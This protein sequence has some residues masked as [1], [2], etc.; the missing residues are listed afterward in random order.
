MPVGAETFHEGLR[1]GA[2]VYQSL[3]KVLHDKGKATTV[4][5][6]GGFAPSDLKSNEQA[7]E[8]IL[9]AIEKAGYKAGEQVMVALDP[10]SS[11]FY[12]DGKY[13]LARENRSLSPEEMIDFYA[14]WMD[15]Y[16]IISLEDGLAEDDWEHWTMLTERIGKKVQLVGDDLL[17]TN[18]EY[19]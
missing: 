5:D 9:E 1:W 2:E 19:I 14:A 18:V 13:V 8:F 15:K 10:A 4:G 16:P 12:K 17:V 6:E 11:E 3:K 7:I